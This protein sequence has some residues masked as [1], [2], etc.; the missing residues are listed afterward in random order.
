MPATRSY[1]PIEAAPEVPDRRESAVLILLVVSGTQG[2]PMIEIP[3]IERTDDGGPHARQI[4]LPGGARDATDA[5]LIETA[6]RESYEE[7]GIDPGTVHPIG[8]LS[9]L[10]IEVSSFVITP[11]VAVTSSEGDP[12]WNRLVPQESEV[13][14][15]LRVPLNSLADTRAE[16]EVDVRGS[17]LPVPSYA[18]HGEII[19]GATAMILSEFL[20]LLPGIIR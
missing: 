17:R 4:A 15:I 6:I 11:V 1:I 3:L 2:N 5:T 16:R 12:F 14:R 13:A 8:L 7:I 20:E 18:I 9:P 10:F 19:W